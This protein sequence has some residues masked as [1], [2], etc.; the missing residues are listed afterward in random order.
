MMGSMVSA[1]SAAPGGT[2]QVFNGVR[3]LSSIFVDL[4]GAG[5]VTVTGSDGSTILALLSTSAAG[6][7]SA[8][9]ETRVVNTGAADGGTG[10]SITITSSGANMNTACI[11]VVPGA[12]TVAVSLPADSVIA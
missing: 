5:V 9:F 3:A 8:H 7:A 10:Q 11:H 12:A 1:K 2:S 6:V 4:D